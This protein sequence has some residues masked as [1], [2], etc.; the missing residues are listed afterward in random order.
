MLSEKETKEDGALA[1]RK[2]DLVCRDDVPNVT[3]S[4]GGRVRDFSFR[5]IFR[6][7]LLCRMYAGIEL[8]ESKHSVGQ[9][10]H[11]R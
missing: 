6:L 4:Q 9:K 10:L 3:I 11:C 1:G 8:Q 2:E 7:Q 5:S